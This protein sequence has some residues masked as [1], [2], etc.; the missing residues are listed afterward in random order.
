MTVEEIIAQDPHG[1]PAELDRSPAP[2]VHAADR[3]TARHF[4][5]AYRDFAD[6]FRAGRRH[7][8][9][10]ARNLL[11]LFP[12]WSFPPPLPFNAPA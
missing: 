11:E 7:L 5:Q 2:F 1:G 9:D 12:L 10:R 8:R 4:R 6:A 3:A